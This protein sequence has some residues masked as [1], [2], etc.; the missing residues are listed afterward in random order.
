MRLEGA[1]ESEVIQPAADVRHLPEFAF[2][3]NAVRL[4][5]WQ[6]LVVGLAGL[7]LVLFAPALWKRAEAFPDEPDYRVPYDLSTDYWL[8]QRHA[9]VAAGRC[10]TFLIGDSVIWGDYVTPHQTLSHYLNERAGRARFANLGLEAAH[11]AA[12]AGLVEH[13]AG[14]VRGRKVVL[15]CNP[16]W[17][18][19]PTQDLQGT[20]DFRFGHPDLVPQ[21]VPRIPC[22]NPGQWPPWK[23]TS[24]RLGHVIDRNVAFSGDRK[25]VV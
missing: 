3:S 7:A 12:L 6:W 2:G 22:Y 17:M 19:D 25:S 14:P 4:S 16:R 13:Y 10:D 24:E 9:E 5:L 15:L 21:F 23:D 20:E 18:I 8:Y 11:P 1:T